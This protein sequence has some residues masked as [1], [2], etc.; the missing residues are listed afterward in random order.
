VKRKLIFIV[1]EVFYFKILNNYK[2]PKHLKTKF[3][4]IFK[5]ARKK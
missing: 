2:K 1:G 5:H 4:K 3:Y